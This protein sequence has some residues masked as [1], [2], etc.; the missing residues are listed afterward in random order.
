MTLEKP[1]PFQEHACS[2]RELLV[3][4]SQGGIGLGALSAVASAAGQAESANQ[5]EQRAP[6]PSDIR[7]TDFER[8]ALRFRIDTTKKAP[9][10]V[11]RKLPMTLNNVRMLLDARV[12]ITRKDS[13]RVHDYV[14]SSSCKAE[15]VW[16]ERDIWHQ[17]NADMCML[18]GRDEFLVYKRWDK[19]DKGVMLF[20]PSLGV[21]PERQ[22]G[23]PQETFDRFSIDLAVRP[24][25]VLGTID[26]ILETLFAN[27]PVV[28][29]TEYETKE[30]RVL[31]EY[32]VRVVNFSERERYYQ[33]DT[34]PILLPD[35]DHEY[36]SLLE[37]CRLAYV[38]H[39]SP[40]WA[41]F[42]VCVRTP[43]TD[44]L[45]VHHYSESIRIDGTRNRMI[46]VS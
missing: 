24:G 2:R 10:T 11:S 21:Q 31:L 30:Y 29:Q 6:S 44:G 13:G 34:G 46:A 37:A 17:P 9:K 14:L 33:V 20:P 35:F 4:A 41:E 39:N 3:S 27:T 22:L 40:G 36:M 42:I 8:S 25:R 26:A 15:Q 16:V 43:V 19:A 32:P 28:A 12:V 5:P 7:V 45:S 18:A 38:A 1:S 23:N